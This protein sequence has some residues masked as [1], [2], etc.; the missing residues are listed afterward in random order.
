MSSISADT[1]I[2]IIFHG[3]PSIALM[4]IAFVCFAIMLVASLWLTI[5]KAPKAKI[6]YLLSVSA[7]LEVI[8]YAARYATVKTA[9]ALGTYILSTAALVIVAIPLS[10]INYSVTGRIV[11]AGQASGGSVLRCCRTRWIGRLFLI[12]DVLCF[13]GAS[14]LSQRRRT[15][16]AAHALPVLYCCACGRYANHR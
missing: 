8:G 14:P 11:E 6:M 10:A 3:Y 7:A 16:A 15:R 13:F 5:A 12:G 4:W 9:P 1:W 2:D